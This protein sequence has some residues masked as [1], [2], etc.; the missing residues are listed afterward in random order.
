MNWECSFTI[1]LICLSSKCRLWSSLGFKIISV[2]QHRGMPW[3]KSESF[4]RC[5]W[6]NSELF[7]K[8]RIKILLLWILWEYPWEW[9]TDAVHL[10]CDTINVTTTD[11]TAFHFASE[12]L[13]KY[14]SIQQHTHVKNDL[15]G[16]SSLAWPFSLDGRLSKTEMQQCCNVW[17]Y[18]YYFAIWISVSGYYPAKFVAKVKT[19]VLL[20]TCAP[21][22]CFA[23]NLALMSH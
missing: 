19:T 23:T 7:L 10:F 13:M 2:M 21:I 5:R 15:I 11:S 22:C 20:C 9:W 6:P 4:S 3:M 12:I 1:F 16:R 18:L 17:F 8:L 14:S